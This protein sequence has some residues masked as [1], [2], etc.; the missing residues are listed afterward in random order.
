LKY[1]FG[2]PHVFFLHVEEYMSRNIPHG[3]NFVTVERKSRPRGSLN[4][5]LG[6]KRNGSV[7]I[8]GIGSSGRRSI[9]PIR[10]WLVGDRNGVERPIR[11]GNGDPEQNPVRYRV[12]SV[13]GSWIRKKSFDA[14]FGIHNSSEVAC[15]AILQTKVVGGDRPHDI[16]ALGRLKNR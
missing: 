14:D 2:R 7:S 11:S 5:G 8:S 1:D 13:R 15:Y 3:W 6:P 12:T 9:V 10:S 4:S 16:V